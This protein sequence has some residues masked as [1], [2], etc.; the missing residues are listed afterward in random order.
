ML[1]WGWSWRR[2]PGKLTTK[3]LNSRYKWDQ[4]S[5]TQCACLDTTRNCLPSLLSPP[6][7]LEPHSAAGAGALEHDPHTLFTYEVG[8]CH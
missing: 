5:V 2:G 7:Q 1:T 6:S 8:A 3:P 4:Q